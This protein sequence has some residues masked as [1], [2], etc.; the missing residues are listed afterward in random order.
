MNTIS[1]THRSGLRGAGQATNEVLFG[2]MNDFKLEKKSLNGMQTIIANLDALSEV[3]GVAIDGML[4]F[5]FLEKGTI[6]INLVKKQFGIRFLIRHHYDQ[7]HHIP[8]P[9][10]LPVKRFNSEC[11]I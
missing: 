5:S 4:G 1:I 9:V 3:Y 10:V 11:T 7:D 2:T 8:G 6:T